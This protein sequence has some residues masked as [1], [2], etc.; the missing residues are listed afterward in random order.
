MDD[1]ESSWPLRAAM[2]AALGAGVGLAAWLLLTGSNGWSHTQD[3][4]RI[5]GASWLV[6]SGILFAFA[7]ERERVGR[8]ALFALAAGLVIASVVYWNG[9]PDQWDDPGRWRLVSAGLAIAIAAPLFQV[10]CDQSGWRLLYSEVHRHAWTNVIIW[11]AAWVFVG[12]VWLLVFLLS[13]LFQLIGIDFIHDLIDEAWFAHMLTGAAFGGAVGLL[14]ERDRIVGTLRRVATAILSVLAPVLGAGLLIFLLALPFT[15]LAPLWE[16]T[17]STTPILLSCVIGALILANAVI[18]DS[19]DDEAKLPPLRYGAMVLAAAMLPLALIAAVSTGLRINQY[20]LTPD[21]LWAVVFTM[22]AS[23]YG[24]A[25]LVSLVRWRLDWGEAVRPANLRL[26][27]GLGALALLLSTPLLSFGAISAHDQ[28]ARLESGRTKA[29]QFDWAA[30]RFDFGPA[31]RRALERLK[32]TAAAPIRAK[33][34]EAL[35][36]TDRW[37]LADK[38]RTVDARAGFAGRVTIFPA[39]VVLPLELIDAM[40]RFSQCGAKGDTQMCIVRYEAGGDLAVLVHFAK[41]C[42]NCAPNVTSLRRLPSGGWG[43]V[44]AEVADTLAETNN[45]RKAAASRGDIEIRKVERKQVFLGE[46]P[47]GQAFE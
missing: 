23:A 8:A 5:A 45:R 21:R 26:A 34:A 27:I 33:A 18:G 44:N 22:I 6:V 17:K 29:D 37:A 43:Q 36:A 42:P 25:Y 46:E 14:R 10:A 2:L 35:A 11:C 4:L 16:A 39:K 7:L 12:I 30:L 38:A 41:D 24:L 1:R 31:G 15:G 19:A 47:V 9:A 13:A 3:P 32:A 20:G 28:I 40:T